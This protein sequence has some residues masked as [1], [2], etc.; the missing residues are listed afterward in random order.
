VH[1]L[2]DRVA[3]EKVEDRPVCRRADARDLRF[4]RWLPG[5]LK[6]DEDDVVRGGDREA[7]IETVKGRDDG[8]D[9][10]ERENPE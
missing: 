5:V 8:A 10:G 9:V 1:D 4:A 6:V 7:A 2:V 3:G